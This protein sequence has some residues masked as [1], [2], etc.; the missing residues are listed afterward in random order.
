[1][2]QSVA[3]QIATKENLSVP[4]EQ[5]MHPVFKILIERA[6]AS[7][8]LLQPRYVLIHVYI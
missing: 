3:D 2:L 5:G 1:M 8:V 4:E 6:P 7:T